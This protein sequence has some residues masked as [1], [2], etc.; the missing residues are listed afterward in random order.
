M[1]DRNR[2]IAAAA[3]DIVDRIRLLASPKE[4]AMALLVAHVRLTT[5]E[6]MDQNAVAGMLAEYRAKFLSAMFEVKT[7]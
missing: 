6:G 7:Q 3:D 2:I 4:A 1:S 5:D